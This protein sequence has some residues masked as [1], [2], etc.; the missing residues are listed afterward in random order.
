MRRWSGGASRAVDGQRVVAEVV[1]PEVAVEAVAEVVG[2]APQC[3]GAGL[4]EALED[5]GDAETGRVGVA[6]HL[7]QGD[8]RT[9][10]RA[11]LVHDGVP[12]VLPSLVD[13]AL[14]GALLVGE[15]AGMAGVAVRVHPRQRRADGGEELTEEGVIGRP[16]VVFGGKHEEEGCRVDAAVVGAVGQFAAA[17]QLVEPQLVQDLAG[18]FVAGVVDALA[19]VGREE[20]EAIAGNLGTVGEHLHRD[21]A[22]IAAEEGV[23]PGRPCRGIGLALRRFAPEHADIAE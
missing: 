11:A 17:R 14:G 15:I 21:D 7:G 20:A 19:L 2:G 9:H 8:G 6:L 10:E 4:A 22:A 1:D 5:S 13:E 12:R 23:E 18:L 3:A 16:L